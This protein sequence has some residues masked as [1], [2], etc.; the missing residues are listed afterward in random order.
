[1]VPCVPERRHLSLAWVPASDEH[2]R[3]PSSMRLDVLQGDLQRIRQP[4]EL[5]T[6]FPWS[7]VANKSKLMYSPCDLLVLRFRLVSLRLRILNL[8][9]RRVGVGVGVLPH[10]MCSPIFVDSLLHLL[11]L[12]SE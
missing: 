9:L 3:N 1:M 5:T 12:L 8:V 11:G 7:V 2:T 10:T 6:M 4:V